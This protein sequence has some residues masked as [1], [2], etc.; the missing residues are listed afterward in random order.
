MLI[1]DQPLRIHT[2]SLILTLYPRP[3]ASTSRMLMKMCAG[4][5]PAGGGWWRGDSRAVLLAWPAAP[6]P[7]HQHQLQGRHTNIHD[8]CRI[9]T[10]VALWSLSPYEVCR[11]CCLSPYD[12]CR[13]VTFSVMTFVALWRFFA[14]HVCCIMTLVAYRVCRS[15]GVYRTVIDL[16]T[17]L[18]VPYVSNTF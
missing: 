12:L 8:V 6:V 11:L 7:P 13:L 3:F 16:F 9:M 10:F 18:P 2:V 5:G 4:E 14:Y 1:Q 17:Y 15:T